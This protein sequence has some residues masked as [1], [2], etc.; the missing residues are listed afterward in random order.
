MAFVTFFKW[1][2][3]LFLVAILAVYMVGRLEFHRGPFFF[4]RM[5]TLD[6]FCG[7]PKR[8]P[9]VCITIEGVVAI[10]T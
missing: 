6:A 7:P 2:F 1:A 5:V 4:Q 3:L 9:D 10:P 8:G